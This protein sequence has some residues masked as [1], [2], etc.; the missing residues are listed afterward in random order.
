MAFVSCAVSGVVAVEFLE[1]TLLKRSSYSGSVPWL[2]VGP[3]VG[4][5]SEDWASL[6]AVRSSGE[7]KITSFIQS[8]SEVD[9]GDVQL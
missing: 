8:S 6:V 9:I 4:S 1:E 2:V 3:K 5:E 7:N